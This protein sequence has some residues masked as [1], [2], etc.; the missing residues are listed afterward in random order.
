MK[1]RIVLFLAILPLI[2]QADCLSRTEVLTGIDFYNTVLR[3]K[4][5][6]AEYRLSVTQGA[7]DIKHLMMQKATVGNL[8]SRGDADFK[9]VKNC[10]KKSKNSEGL[11]ALAEFSES[12]NEYV[13][14]LLD[15]QTED[16]RYDYN[17][18]RLD[19]VQARK[20]KAVEVFM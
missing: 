2:A 18:D 14:A 1:N 6:R 8:R 19:K 5:A 3:A 11:K 13:D 20:F 7:P 9:T 10:L 12:W 4:L 15:V 17:L 16:G